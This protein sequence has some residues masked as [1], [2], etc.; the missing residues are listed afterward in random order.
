QTSHNFIGTGD[1]KKQLHNDVSR[2]TDLS[3]VKLSDPKHVRVLLEGYS[4]WRQDI[5]EQGNIDEEFSKLLNRL[6]LIIEVANLDHE[7]MYIIGLV[8][9]SEYTHR[10]ILE[11]VNKKFENA[12]NYRQINYAITESIPNKIARVTARTEKAMNSSIHKNIY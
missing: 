3:S 10:Q 2:Y 8:K 1:N 11:L 4:D 9:Q 7:E 6:D 5:V 12:Y